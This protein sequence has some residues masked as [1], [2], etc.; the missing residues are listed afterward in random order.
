MLARDEEE[1]LAGVAEACRGLY[2]DWIILVDDRDSGLTCLAA[3]QYLEGPGRL[4]PF[5]FENFSQARNLLFE[6][7]RPGTEWLLLVDPDSPPTGTLPGLQVHPWYECEWKMGQTT[8][9]L[10]ILV[11]AD[12]E[13]R[14]EGACHE[15]LIIPG[16]EAGGFAEE[17]RV[18]VAVKPFSPARAEFYLDLLLPEA[19][20]SA[21][22]AFYL[23][24]TYADL[25]RNGE[26]IEAYL[27]CA[28]MLQPPEQAYLCVQY[29]GQLLAALDVDL[30]RVLFERA[31][32]MRPSRG[33]TLYSLAWLANQTGDV[34]QAAAYCAEGVQLPPCPDT[35]FVNRWAE[36]DGILLELGRALNVLRAAEPPPTLPTEED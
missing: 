9:R 6:E 30:A 11:R 18:D 1:A 17:L 12:L 10:P 3:T 33:E 14:Y 31:H 23:A 2:D 36:H 29:A 8:W 20:E 13:C 28:Q 15:L 19:Q 27:Y 7:A 4:V 26:A 22:S 25:E 24:R 5:T 35:L 34:R 16:A 21:R 32:A